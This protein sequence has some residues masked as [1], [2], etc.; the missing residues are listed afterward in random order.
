MY[1]IVRY[2]NGK[3]CDGYRGGDKLRKISDITEL[4]LIA[5]TIRED[6]IR[7]LHHAKS[8][9]P[10]GPLGMT[11]VF[12]ALYFNAMNHDPKHPKWPDRDRLILSN[13]HIVPVLYATL[14]RAGYF[15]P[16][17]LK[18]LRQLD[19]RLQGHPH[20]GCAPGV[21][22]TAGPLGQGTSIACG[23]AY[24]AKMDK[25]KFKVFLSMGDGELNE[26]QVWEAFMFAA[27]YKLDNIIGF[28]D[29][30]YIQID[31]FTEEVMPLDPLGVKFNAFGWN[32]IEI[33]GNNMRSVVKAIERAKKMKGK[34]TVII[35]TTIPGKGVEFMEGKPE[36]HGKP[37]NTEQAQVALHELSGDEAHL[38]GLTPEEARK[39]MEK[40]EHLEGE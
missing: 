1:N 20:I 26:G 36:W 6:I 18:T 9:H 7:M 10:A 16:S 37:P 2:I 23:I 38:R 32:V 33:D 35:C 31:G 19:S 8:G 25:K 14:A 40:S 24:G 28:V 34:P 21:E 15:R 27:K 22:N 12:T 3:C 11:D 30:N 5:Y 29:R 13:G 39:L 17:E 4:R